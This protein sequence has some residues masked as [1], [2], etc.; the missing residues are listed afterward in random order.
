MCYWK[1][2]HQYINTLVKLLQTNETKV[3]MIASATHQ[4]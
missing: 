4:S 1:I 3:E 2:K